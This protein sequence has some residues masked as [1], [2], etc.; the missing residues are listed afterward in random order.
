MHRFTVTFGDYINNAAAAGVI[1]SGTASLA[2]PGGVDAY[3]FC[4]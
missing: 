2:L 3:L 1:G 4:I